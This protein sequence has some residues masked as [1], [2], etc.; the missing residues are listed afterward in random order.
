MSIYY[1]KWLSDDL[2]IVFIIQVSVLHLWNNSENQLTN[3]DLPETRLQLLQ[4]LHN[5]DSSLAASTWAN[6]LRESKSS[7]KTFNLISNSR[8][9]ND[10]NSVNVDSI[11]IVSW[12]FT[13]W[14]KW[15]WDPLSS[16]RVVSIYKSGLKQRLKVKHA[17]VLF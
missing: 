4:T 17:E 8:T 14:H 16:N 6:N 15:I 2:I 13:S 1:F 7:S 5:D 10:C 3:I 12:I 11:L 9:S